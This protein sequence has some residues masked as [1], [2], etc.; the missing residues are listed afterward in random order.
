MLLIDDRGKTIHS[1]PVERA[2]APLL[3]LP[4]GTSREFARAVLHRAAHGDASGFHGLWEALR[5]ELRA[6]QEAD[7]AYLLEAAARGIAGGSILAASLLPAA[8][9]VTFLETQAVGDP[10]DRVLFPGL[11][12][13]TLFAAGLLLRPDTAAV[14][15]AWSFGP[16]IGARPADGPPEATLEALAAAFANHMLLLKPVAPDGW[17]L[18][19]R[20]RATATVWGGAEAAAAPPP[21]PPRPA[22]Q[23]PPPRPSSRP[24]SS[25]PQ[26]QALRDAAASGVPFCEECP[27]RAA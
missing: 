10:F 8:P 2:T 13:A 1:I 4:R 24:P 21:P 14:R 27:R 9:D 25:S 6:P 22:R 7:R 15:A 3:P 16:R 12:V 23:P 17:T 19:L 5:R 20:W 11:G 26:A 18:Q